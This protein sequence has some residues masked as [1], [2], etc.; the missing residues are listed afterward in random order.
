MADFDGEYLAGTTA[1]LLEDDTS[2]AGDA[3]YRD[4]CPPIDPDYPVI[5]GL[6][7]DG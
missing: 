7:S 2:G 5:S 1:E 3:E 6:E 4:P